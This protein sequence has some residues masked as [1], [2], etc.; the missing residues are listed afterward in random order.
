MTTQQLKKLES[1]LWSAA[2]KMRADSDLK[3]SEF[4]TPILGLIFLKF[5]DNKYSAVEDEINAELKAQEN[6]RRQ[7]Q[8]HEIAIE[9]CG[10]YLPAESRYDYLLN[11]PEKE[12][13]AKAIKQAMAAIEKYKPELENT[14][15]QDEY[16]D[17]TRNDKNLP[18]GENFIKDIF[19]YSKRCFRRY[20]R[21]NIRVL[22]WEIRNG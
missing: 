14:L 15:P 7:R 19:G 17:L 4:A 1:D 9:K 5:T 10:F 11:L 18:G 2:I 22:P 12:D 20:F 16:Y 21:K 6:S 13:I 3:L 8:V